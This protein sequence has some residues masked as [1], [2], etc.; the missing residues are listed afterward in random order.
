MQVI[1]RKG[2]L[3]KVENGKEIIAERGRKIEVTEADYKRFRNNFVPV[4]T[5]K[6]AEVKKS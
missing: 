1:P 6:V 3:I 4:E 2:F 5:A